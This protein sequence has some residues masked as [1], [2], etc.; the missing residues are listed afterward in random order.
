MINDKKVKVNKQKPSHACSA[1]LMLIA[2]K[3]PLIQR[4]AALAAIPLL[5]VR[6]LISSI[7]K[8]LQILANTLFA[9][10]TF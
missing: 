7:Y 2:I 5:A 3:C 10:R 8:I 9:T 4:Q 1:Q 6:A